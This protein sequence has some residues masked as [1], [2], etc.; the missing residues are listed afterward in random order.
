M[1]HSNFN[2][3]AAAKRFLIFIILATGA[4]LLF[5]AVVMLL[6]NA[7][8]PAIVNAA[9]ITYWQAVGLLVLCKIL[10][11]DFRPRSSGGRPSFGRSPYW[12]DKWATMN[13]E[14]KKTFKE[15]WKKRCGHRNP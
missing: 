6:W 4:I 10:F 13:D 8:M 14:E 7:V 5:G 12:K 15:E 2:R 9:V 1:M 11:S 3:K